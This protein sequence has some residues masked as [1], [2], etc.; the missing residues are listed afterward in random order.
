MSDTGRTLDADG[1]ILGFRLEAILE[2]DLGDMAPEDLAGKFIELNCMFGLIR[3]W[4]QTVEPYVDE[5][6]GPGH[7]VTLAGRPRGR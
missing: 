7:W 1:R 5:M 6:M 4:V 3:G 2:G